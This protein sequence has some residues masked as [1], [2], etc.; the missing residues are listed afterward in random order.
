MS[1]YLFVL[2]LVGMILA[3][4]YRFA[5]LGI[6]R[7]DLQ[8]NEE[9]TELIQELNRSLVKMEQRIEALET[10]LVEQGDTKRPPTFGE[11]MRQRN[12]ADR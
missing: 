9:E 8:Y 1:G 4:G 12:D 6:Q 2:C 11:V 3:F 7:K 10:L 5:R